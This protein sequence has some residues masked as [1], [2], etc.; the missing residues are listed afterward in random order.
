MR[1]AV[2]GNQRV[3][4]DRQGDV[5]RPGCGPP[6]IQDPCCDP[7][8]TPRHGDFFQEVQRNILIE[9]FAEPTPYMCGVKRYSPARGIHG[10]DRILSSAN[11]A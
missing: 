1:Y 8:T 3:F 4:E 9:R 5:R 6:E 10:C 7:D 11:P 2:K